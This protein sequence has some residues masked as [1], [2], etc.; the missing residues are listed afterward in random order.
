MSTDTIWHVT[1]VRQQPLPQLVRVRYVTLIRQHP[2]P[3]LF[4]QCCPRG[5]AHSTPRSAA[6]IL[7]ELISTPLWPTDSPLP[8]C[9]SPPQ[10]FNAP[11]LVGA[12][13]CD[14]SLGLAT[15]LGRLT[16]SP[17]AVALAL[18]SPSGTQGLA[19]PAPGGVPASAPA[20]GPTGVA[21]AGAGGLQVQVLASPTSPSMPP[22]LRRRGSESTLG[23]SGRNS[24][25]TQVGRGGDG[26]RVQCLSGWGL[27][28]AAWY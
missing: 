2:L 21:G 20:P 26:G 24:S 23:G 6:P 13:K 14:D 12:S 17:S 1:H 9:G 19:P 22:T 28:H 10:E 25:G 3:Q 18:A 15:P 27:A 5:Y 8:L 16:P 4:P 7:Q 11:I